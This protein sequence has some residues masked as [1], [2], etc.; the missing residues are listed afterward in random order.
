MSPCSNAR[1]ATSSPRVTSSMAGELSTPSVARRAED[2]V[3]LGGELARAAPEI[4]E[5][6]RVDGLHQRQQIEERRRALGAEPVVLVRVPVVVR[7]RSARLPISCIHGRESGKTIRHSPQRS[8]TMPPASVEQEARAAVRPHQGGP[9]EERPQREEGGG[10]RGA[11]RQQGAGVRR[12]VG[13]EQPQ[14]HRRHLVGTARWPA[15]AQGP[16]RAHQG[17]ALQ[18]G[19]AQEHQGAAPRCRRRSSSVP[20]VAEQAETGSVIRGSGS[21]LV[22]MLRRVSHAVSGGMPPHSGCSI[23]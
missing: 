13:D 1:P 4:G 20:S 6:R 21:T 11:H 12:R 17:A 15:L 18:R 8:P 7:H 2:A 10:D 3:G 9:E 22:S 16:G 23:M 19:Q 5:P 14:L